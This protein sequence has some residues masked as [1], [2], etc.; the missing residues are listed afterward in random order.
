MIKHL[1]LLRERQ[2]T[3]S[4]TNTTHTA[5]GNPNTIYLCSRTTSKRVGPITPPLQPSPQPRFHTSCSSEVC[6]LRGVRA[7]ARF[8]GVLAV[9]GLAV[10]GCVPLQNPSFEADVLN[11]THA[12]LYEYRFATPGSL[13]HVAP[14]LAVRLVA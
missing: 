1:D 14:N 8:L 7:L 12:P 6:L 3:P 2:A 11:G 9:V 10:G 13:G 5:H 4:T